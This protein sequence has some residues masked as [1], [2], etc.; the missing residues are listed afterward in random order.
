MTLSYAFSLC[1][2]GPLTDGPV[3]HVHVR[4]GRL[5]ARPIRAD[6]RFLVVACPHLRV[7]SLEVFSSV[8]EKNNIGLI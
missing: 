1:S 2:S 3:R 7:F 4:V 6:M 8:E 5:S